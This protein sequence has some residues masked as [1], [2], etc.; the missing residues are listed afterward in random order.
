M[1]A[2]TRATCRKSK[3]ADCF[4]PAGSCEKHRSPAP[5]AEFRPEWPWDRADSSSAPGRCASSHTAC[6]S[7]SP[8][9]APRD[10]PMSAR[11]PPPNGTSLRTS[12]PI[13]SAMRTIISKSALVPLTS[14]AFFTSCRSPQVLVNGAGLLVSI[15][16]G[17]H[18]VGHRRRFRSGTCPARRRKLFANAKGSMFNRPTGFEP[19]TYSAFSLPALRGFNHLG[20]VEARCLWDRAPL[21][22]K[23]T[24]CLRPGD[25]R[26][27]GRD[28]GPCRPRRASSHNRPG[29]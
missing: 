13:A 14:P 24:D 20:Q 17:Q 25:S 29:K 22:V 8:D 10:C 15:G 12:N 1:H 26:A 16:R 21:L 28:K 3:C 27:A 2:L 6:R 23:F 9:C 11:V 18:H 5:G 4:P 7:A 19:T